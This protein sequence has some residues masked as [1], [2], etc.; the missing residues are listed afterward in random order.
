M[1]LI[2]EPIIEV[3]GRGARRRVTVDG[4]PIPRA[5]Y[6]SGSCYYDDVLD[7]YIKVGRLRA[8]RERQVWTRA[9][10]LG[11]D[12]YLAPILYEGS[13]WNAYERVKVGNKRRTP[14]RML[15][16]Q[17]LFTMLRLF[18]CHDR[19]WVINERG[20]VVLVDYES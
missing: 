17:L 11:V 16:A 9:I 20:D 4:R 13:N 15:I 12:S 8:R 6:S 2:G 7:I 3:R 18:D 5:K 14:D 10:M 1:T 19:N